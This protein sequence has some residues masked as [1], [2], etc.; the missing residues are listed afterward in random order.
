MK[1]A[2]S[3]TSVPRSSSSSD[4]GSMAVT[5]LKQKIH[6]LEQTLRKRE[7]DINDFKRSIGNTQLN[8]MKVE[9]EVYLAE[10]ARYE[11]G[12]E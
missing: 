1:T 7:D 4:S 12:T 3:K 5:S 9:L 11:T 6:A 2:A 10:I 8:E